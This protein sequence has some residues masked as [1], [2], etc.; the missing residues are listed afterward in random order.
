[1]RLRRVMQTRPP[2]SSVS[3]RSTSLFAPVLITISGDEHDRADRNV[4]Y[5]SGPLSAFF[6]GS[7]P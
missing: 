2:L 6:L 4:L 5:A 3:V 7:L 1:M